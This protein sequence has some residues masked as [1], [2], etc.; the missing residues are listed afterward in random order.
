[1][2]LSW[3]RWVHGC[4]FFACPENFSITKKSWGNKL[5]DRKRAN[6]GGRKGWQMTYEERGAQEKLLPSSLHHDHPGAKAL[7]AAAVFLALIGGEMPPRGPQGW[8]GSREGAV[9]SFLTHTEPHRQGHPG[10]PQRGATARVREHSV[11][12]CGRLSGG[13][14]RQRPLNHRYVLGPWPCVCVVS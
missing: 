10:P 3:E 1:M 4:C 11:C 13:R 5:R 14:A 6:K 7:G 8:I 9:Q 2:F 12:V